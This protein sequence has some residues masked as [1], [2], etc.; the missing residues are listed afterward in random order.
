MILQNEKSKPT[1]Q[2]RRWALAIGGGI[3]G[4]AIAVGGLTVEP[5]CVVAGQ[6]KA[7]EK[8]PEKKPETP[9]EKPKE[10]PKAP[11]ANDHLREAM[12]KLK[13]DLGEDSD[14]VKELD[15]IIKGFNKERPVAPPARTS[16]PV[17]SVRAA[18]PHAMR[19][20][21]TMAT[22]RTSRSPE[23]GESRKVHTTG[24]L[25]S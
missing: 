16:A 17:W 20:N 23:I 22:R 10:R 13:K 5:R 25:P 6:E 8:A 9:K 18:G 7:P 21:P 12:E 2:T 19:T 14:A 24:S 1:Y 11:V 3:A 15:E 4:L